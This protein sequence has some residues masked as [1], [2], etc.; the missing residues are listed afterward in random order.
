[1]KP[2]TPEVKREAK[3]IHNRLYDL[4]NQVETTGETPEIVAERKRLHERLAELDCL[5]RITAE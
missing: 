5:E 3:E 2:L 4:R 1:M